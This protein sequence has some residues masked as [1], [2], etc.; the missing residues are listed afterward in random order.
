MRRLYDVP[1]TCPLGKP[2]YA[3]A[4]ND[5]LIPISFLLTFW[6]KL[7]FTFVQSKMHFNNSPTLNTTLK[8]AFFMNFSPF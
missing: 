5:F 8:I 6:L 4:S 1:T 3:I 2:I 7:N